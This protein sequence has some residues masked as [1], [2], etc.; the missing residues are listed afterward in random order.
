MT[1]SGLAGFALVFVLTTWSLSAI[2]GLALRGGRARLRG[3]GATVERGAATAVAIVPVG[4]AAALVAAL[5]A[6]AIAGPDH[7]ADHAHHAHL[8]F[9]HGEGWLDRAWVTVVLAGTGAVLAVRGGILGVSVVRGARGVAQLRAV[10]AGD[11][12][13]RVVASERAFCF[14]AGLVR[15]AIYVSSRAWSSLSADER[16]VLVAHEAAHVR[17]GDLRRHML[18]EGF[19]VLAA[20]RV[21]AIVRTQW[22]AATERRCDAEAVAATGDAIAVASAMVA[23]ARLHST[24][25]AALL[26]F[27][28]R[29]GELAARVRAVLEGRPTGARAARTLTRVIVAAAVALVVAASLAAGPLHHAL[30]SLLG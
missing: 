11:D 28:P 18:V 6:H 19:L 21:A 29:P 8:C 13:V 12:P 22:R 10:S 9:A 25:P 15:P 24:P 14:V 16:A 4:L 17:H 30:E 23:M 1:A 26:A 27:A 20:P 5:G 2:G 7:C 3:L